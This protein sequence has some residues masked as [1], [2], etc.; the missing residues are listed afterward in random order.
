[1]ELNY[2]SMCFACGE[3]NDW[4]LKLKFSERDGYV[5]T[6]L[7]PKEVYEGYPGI[8]HGGLNAAILDEVM[9]ITVN[10]LGHDAVTARMELRF[11]KEVPTGGKVKYRSRIKSSR[12]KVFDLE[13]EAVLEDGT[14]AVE[15]TGRY[16]VVGELKDRE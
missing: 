1:M 3:R 13:S 4:G 2:D 10:S 5:E 8:M 15:A 14:V 9:A 7:I 11:R 16:I 6:E 12:G